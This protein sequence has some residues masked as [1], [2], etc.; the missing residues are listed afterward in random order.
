MDTS[1]YKESVFEELINEDVQNY[2]LN[3]ILDER[4]LVAKNRSYKR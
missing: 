3:S 1:V 4:K 2:I